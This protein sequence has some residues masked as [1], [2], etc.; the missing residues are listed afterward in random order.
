MVEWADERARAMALLRS[1]IRKE[2]KVEQRR[3]ALVIHEITEAID[4]LK[5]HALIQYDVAG[6]RYWHIPEDDSYWATMPGERLPT[7]G[8]GLIAN[9]VMELTRWEF[10]GRQQINPDDL[11]SA[12]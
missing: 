12:I 3:P 4:A 2:I 6:A 7:E 5:Q 9:L 8:S 1:Y 10:L 11:D